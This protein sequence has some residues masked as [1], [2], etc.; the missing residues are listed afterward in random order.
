V[1]FHLLQIQIYY[2]RCRSV[3]QG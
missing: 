3:S 2:Y 1:I